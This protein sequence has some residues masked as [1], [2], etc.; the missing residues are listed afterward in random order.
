LLLVRIL[1][2]DPFQGV[3]VLTRVS[4]LEAAKVIGGRIR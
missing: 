1:D 2:R 4:E 3:V